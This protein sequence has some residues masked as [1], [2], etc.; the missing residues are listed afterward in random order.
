MQQQ[1]QPY[2]KEQFEVR[3]TDSVFLIHSQFWLF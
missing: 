1:G 3:D 2:F